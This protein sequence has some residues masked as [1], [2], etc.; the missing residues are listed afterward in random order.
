MERS[1]LLCESDSA[2]QAL[3]RDIPSKK[4]TTREK[5]DIEREVTAINN[6][7]GVLTKQFSSCDVWPC[8]SNV[9]DTSRTEG[10]R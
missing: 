3:P 10:H 1:G 5:F 7:C 4:V 2:P 6:G 9:V 8:D